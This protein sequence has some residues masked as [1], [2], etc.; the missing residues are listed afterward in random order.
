MVQKIEVDAEVIYGLVYAW[1]R[2]IGIKQIRD[3]DMDE[4]SFIRGAS[5][6]SDK[7][8]ELVLKEEKGAD[9]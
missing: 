4:D 3:A 9:K 5:V 6:F 8:R 1:V 2:H 7:L